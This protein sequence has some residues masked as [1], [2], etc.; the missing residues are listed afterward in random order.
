MLRYLM[1]RMA[2]FVLVLFAIT[3]AAARAAGGLRFETSNWSNW[4]MTA[5]THV[6][7]GDFD[8][9]GRDDVMKFDNGSPGGL[10]V[11]LARNGSFQTTNWSNWWMTAD[12]HVLAGD[13][14]GDGRDDVMKFDNGAPGGLWVGLSRGDGSAANP[15]RYATSNWSNWWMTADT[16]VLA[17][18]FDGDGRDDVM[19]FDNGSPGG[20]WVGLSRGDG[21][22][23]NPFGY[24]TSR[25]ADWLMS[26]GL[27]VLAGDFDGDHRDDVVKF[28]NGSPGGLWVGLVREGNFAGPR[29][30]NGQG[31]LVTSN[32]RAPGPFTQNLL[33]GLELSPDGRTATITSFPT[34]VVGPFSTP[35]GNNTTTIT[36]TGGGT[37]SFDPSTGA[38]DIPITL[39]F[40]QSH[41]FAGDSDASCTL[42]TGT[43]RSPGGVFAGTGVPL[44][45]PSGTT[46]VVCGFRF[47]GGFLGGDDGFLTVAGT[48]TPVP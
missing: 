37:G 17:G 28:D 41:V 35:V 46:S 14:D 39:H 18:D 15:F 34:I 13:F 2:V 33:V 48:I 29:T 19:M 11:G 27:H 40:D 31:T 23:A 1:T 8:G 21:S 12:T 45:R 36:K 25:W 16:H 42:T 44:T 32:M 5:D 3:P 10:W 47:Q 30:F 6:L 7:A 38:L 24:A 22:A 9:D 4:W 20:L 26:P 43:S